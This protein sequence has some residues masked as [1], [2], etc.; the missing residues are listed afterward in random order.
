MR[1]VPF[2]YAVLA[3]LVGAVGAA[4]TSSASPGSAEQTGPAF[5]GGPYFVLVCGV[6]HRNNDD[7]IVFPNQPGR[8]H[9]H[10]YIGNRTVDASSTPASIRDGPTTCERDEDSSTYWAPTLYVAR[11]AVTPLV[12][13]VYYARRT[14][15]RVVP[16]PADLKMVAGDQHARRAQSKAIVSWSCGG[17][18]R[19][20][21]WAVIPAC[22]ETQALQLR[23]HFPNCWNGRSSDSVDH[24]RHMAYSSS[25]RCPTSHPVAVPTLTLI[26]LYAAVPKRAQVASGKFG[27]HADFMNGWDEAELAR[28]VAELNY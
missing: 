4:A 15:E 23:V 1:R 8:A 5:P 24:K 14:S 13:L 16:F 18:G 3:T 22:S 27:G 25:G 17:L 9:N 6:S 10:T 19:T 20:K 26:F 28:L 12:G 21:R 7:P 2:R 11:E